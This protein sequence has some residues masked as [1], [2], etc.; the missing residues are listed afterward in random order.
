MC[1]PNTCAFDRPCLALY[2]QAKDATVALVGELPV[3]EL[4][5]TCRACPARSIQDV[6]AHHVHVAGEYVGGTFAEEAYVAIIGEQSQRAAAAATRDIW[7]ADGVLS[8]R[9]LDLAAVLAEWDAV[10]DRM[11]DRTA[12][13]GL[14]SVMHQDDIAET[15]GAADPS[16][17]ALSE[18]ALGSWHHAFLV[19]R[20]ATTGA[21]VN[22]VATDTGRRWTKGGDNPTVAG[23]AYDLLRAVGGRRTRAQA[24]ASLDWGDAPEE[25]RA[26]LAVYGWPG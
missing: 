15:L 26:L 7:T 1:S 6:V 5:R 21:C 2:Q 9:N 8:R 17:Y 4:T 13:I 25:T 16:T 3:A 11:D 12:G 18:D 24:D 20:L 14:D 19:P 10:V 22:L 23:P